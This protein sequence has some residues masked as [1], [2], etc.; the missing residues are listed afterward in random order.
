[1]ATCAICSTTILFGGVT[2]GDLRFCSDKCHAGG[3]VHSVAEQVPDEVIEAHTLQLFHGLCPKCNSTGPVDVH[4]SW[5]IYSALVFTS[6]RP[7]EHVCCLRCARKAQLL[8]L[9]ASSVVGWWGFPW[10]IIMTPVY[11]VKNLYALL[12]AEAPLE[13]S[14]A[15]RAHVR[16]GAAIALLEEGS[17]G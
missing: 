14:E 6:Y 7:R 8:D 4:H 13:P 11:I 10:G 17:V 16:M 3:L 12:T 15:L 9:A 5:F 1:M 2:D